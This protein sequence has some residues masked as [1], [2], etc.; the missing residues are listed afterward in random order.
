MVMESNII[1]LILPNVNSGEISSIH[2][3]KCQKGDGVSFTIDSNKYQLVYIEGSCPYK[4]KVRKEIDDRIKII[5]NLKNLLLDI[6]KDQVKKRKS[7]ISDMEIFGVASIKL[8]IHL[9]AL[10]F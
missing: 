9:Y 8:N 10:S 3:V 2:H 6:I 1:S 5:R 7:I 4:V